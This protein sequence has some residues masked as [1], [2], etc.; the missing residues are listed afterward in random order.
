MSEAATAQ[1][2]TDAVETENTSTD[3]ALTPETKVK[4]VKTAEDSTAKTTLTETKVPEK[5]DLKLP[6]NS[7]L[8]AAHLEKI[9][10]YAK[11][12]GFSNDMAQ[13]LLERES[14]AVESYNNAQKDT[15]QKI[16]ES[17]VSEAKNDKEI[18]G[19]AFKQNTELAKRVVDRFG[20]DPFKK[21][22]NETGLGNHPE[23]LRVFTRIGKAM[24]E[25][26][27]IVPGAQAASGKRS[28]EDIFYGAST[29]TT[30]E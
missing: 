8:D 30:K 20:T 26:K 27:L 13:A 16:G 15:L 28:I 17:W 12:K 1:T 9:S 14:L 24:S 23:L 29:K 5:Y 11:E 7:L 22:L 10:S 21:A 18:G 25:D 19:E 6:E 2:N 3:V 4:D